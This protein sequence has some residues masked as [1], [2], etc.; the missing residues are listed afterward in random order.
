MPNVGQL[1]KDEMTRVSR[2]TVRTA[3]VPLLAQIRVLKKT[4]RA[5]TADLAA[6][7]KIIAHPAPAAAT[8][9]EVET[10][11]ETTKRAWTGKRIRAL[12]KKLKLTQVQLATLVGVSSQSVVLWEKRDTKIALRHKTRDAM[13]ALK[14]MRKADL[15]QALEK[16]KRS[17]QAAS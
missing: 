4:V 16:A 10:G 5:L 12:R 2:K 14:Q 7:R 6:L 8:A 3:T 1:L 11:A 9:T 17:N 15:A 13:T